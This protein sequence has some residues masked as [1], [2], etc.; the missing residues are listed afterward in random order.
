MWLHHPRSKQ[1]DTMLTFSVLAIGS[2][3]IKF[4]ANG[5]VLDFGEYSINLGTIDGALIAAL[6]TPTLVAYVAR[7]NKN[8]PE[9]EHKE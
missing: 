6:L 2:C 5:I 4:L 8:P 1:P 3:L 9:E 7:K